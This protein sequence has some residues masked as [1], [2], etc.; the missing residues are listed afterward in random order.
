MNI[1]GLCGLW[2]SMTYGIVYVI[3]K[4]NFI[5]NILITKFKN[6]RQNILP[7]QLNAKHPVKETNLEQLD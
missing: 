7:L 4:F 5:Y 3:M 6:G 1:T 2:N